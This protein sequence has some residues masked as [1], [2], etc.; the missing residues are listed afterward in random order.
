MK[1]FPVLVAETLLLLL[2]FPLATIRF[3]IS[4]VRLL[5]GGGFGKPYRYFGR[6]S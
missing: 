5:L 2:G 6:R 3:G 4:Q 1:G